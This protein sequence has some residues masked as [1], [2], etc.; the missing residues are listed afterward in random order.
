MTAN[1]VP[2]AR[3]TGP[4]NV[5]VGIPAIYNGSA[6]EDPG[7]GGKIVRWSLG[8]SDGLLLTEGRG[9]P[10]ATIEL[11]F[12]EIGDVD[13]VLT[14][15]DI[16][17][18]YG[19][20]AL[21]VSVAPVPAAVD[22]V[23]SEWSAWSE[24]TSWVP[25]GDG[26]ESRSQSRTRTIAVEAANG[27]AAC[28][29]P[30]IEINA[31]TRYL[32]V[33][34][35]WGPWSEFGDWSAWAPNG[36]DTESRTRTRT[37]V[38]ETPSAHGGVD[39]TGP[40][41]ETETE[42]RPIAEPPPSWPLQ[43]ASPTGRNPKLLWSPEQQAVWF[44]MR[45]EAETG[46]SSVGATWFNLIK[47]N[48]LGNRYGDTGIW[49]TLMYQMTGDEQ[50]VAQAMRK[51][52]AGLFTYTPTTGQIGNAIREN[53]MEWVVLYDWLYPGLTEAQ[54]AQFRAQLDMLVTTAFTNASLPATAPIRTND[55][56]QVTGVYFGTA[57]YYIAAGDHH[58]PAV[59][60]WNHV[61]VG[62]WD[63]TGVNRLTLRNAVATFV[64]MAVGG[65]C[66]SSEY[67]MGTMKLLLM[68][69]RGVTQAL[70]VDHF[71][72]MGPWMAKAVEYTS[73]MLTPDM[74]D[75]LQWGDNQTVRGF[76]LYK[77]VG[78]SM[79]FDSPIARE[80]V[81]RFVNRFGATGTASAEPALQGVRG[82]FFFDP[83]GTRQSIDTL[84]LTFRVEGQGLSAIHTSRA[85]DASV[86]FTHFPQR[87]MLG[88]VDHTVNYHGDIQLYRKGA[89]ALTHPIAY[90]G[91]PNGCE[92]VNSAL[93]AGMNVPI[94]FR[95]AQVCQEDA[96]SVYLAGTVGGDTVAETGYYPPPSFY[97]EWSRSILWLKGEPDILVVFDRK[98]IEDPRLLPSYDRY[99]STLRTVMNAAG[100]LKQTVWHM[101]VSPTI[102][103]N[104]ITWPGAQIDVLDAGRV[105]EIVNETTAWVAGA[106]A[107]SEKKFH[108]RVQEPGAPDFNTSLTVIRLGDST[109]TSVEVVEAG[110]V[111]GVLVHRAGQ[112]DVLVLFNA[113][114][115]P[116]VAQKPRVVGTEPWPVANQAMLA[117]VRQRTTG[118]TVTW[119]SQTPETLV[120]L[121]EQ[122]NVVDVV[123]VLG[124]G[125]QTLTR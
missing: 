51:V 15:W 26:T 86:L 70:G 82:F 73:Q 80:A 115:G 119:T 103:G 41:S 43:V 48:A 114:A 105:F 30:A 121:P 23:W 38:I 113:V 69:H 71:P 12:S 91:K 45:V 99:S 108:V 33:D 54:R 59:D 13:V 32:P 83:Y 34:C 107:T 11:T 93:A 39:C 98:H 92:G 53:L 76:A 10:P 122:N 75:P 37:R 8:T 24:W 120:Y 2:I 63:V 101:P 52:E 6:S 7:S 102:D 66:E 1:R 81:Y 19:I 78:M 124:A 49:A 79:M 97:H 118:Y 104:T 125:P 109:G 110:D 67:D 56:D 58:Q 68:G 96:G 72:E 64:T 61:Q 55:S 87:D 3:L 14:V 74:E 44:R 46:V 117:G 5:L 16:H 85:A 42:T 50:W 112:S 62:G 29:G 88:Y 84:P 57:F 94:E 111:R 31:E 106:A 20:A 89:W 65:W 47:S 100:T 4:T 95:G 90:G 25:N 9:L 27:G 36:D 28:S 123:T 21:A 35:V 77:W 116:K 40:S 18:F 60:R 17:G 22:C